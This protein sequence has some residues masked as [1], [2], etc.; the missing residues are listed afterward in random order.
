MAKKVQGLDLKQLKHLAKAGAEATLARLRAEIQAIEH[1]FPELSTSRGR[2]KAANAV[3]KQTR[4]MSDAAR[5]AVSARMK[6]YWAARRKS[7][8]SKK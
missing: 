3:A 2:H 7:G 6:R 8:A 4:T 5:K 1:T